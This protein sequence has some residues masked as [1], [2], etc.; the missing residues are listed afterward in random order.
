MKQKQGYTLRHVCG[1][2][3]IMYTGKTEGQRK[4]YQ[5]SEAAAWLWQQATGQG[6][7]TVDSLVEALCS[8]YDIEP[9]EARA[10]IEELVAQWMQESIIEL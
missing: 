4:V 6:D 5:L 2:P 10:D 8:E 3:V 1:K 9:A 7:F